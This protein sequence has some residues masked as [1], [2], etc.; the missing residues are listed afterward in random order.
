MSDLND[1]RIGKKTSYFRNNPKYISLMLEVIDILYDSFDIEIEKEELLKPITSDSEEELRNM[2][3]KHN[4][5]LK[6]KERKFVLTDDAGNVV[7]KPLS[8]YNIFMQEITNKIEKEGGK[9][10]TIQELSKD[11]NSLSKKEQNK[12]KKLS[13]KEKEKF[14]V[15]IEEQKKQAIASGDF[16]KPKPKKPKS[17]YIYFVNDPENIQFYKEQGIKGI[18][19]NTESSKRWREMTDEE[20]EPYVKKYEESRKEYEKQMEV[21]YKEVKAIKEKKLKHDIELAKT[22]K[23]EHST[24]SKDENANILDFNY[25]CSKCNHLNKIKIDQSKLIKKTILNVNDKLE[26]NDSGEEDD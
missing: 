14:N 21:Y 9:K 19:I 6:R 2:I 20:K 3:K 4:K 22:F 12:Y 18:K 11:W 15:M 24:S 7:K 13:D 17:A 8:G 26:E 5:S 25:L 10:K 1:F 16:D 23:K